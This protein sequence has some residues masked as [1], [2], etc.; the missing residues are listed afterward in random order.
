MSNGQKRKYNRRQEA[1]ARCIAEKNGQ[2]NIHEKPVK[3]TFSIIV[4]KREVIHTIEVKTLKN[5]LV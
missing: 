4:P 2:F 3:R 1:A 5:I